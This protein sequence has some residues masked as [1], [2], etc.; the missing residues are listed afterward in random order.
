M[1]LAAEEIEVLR[2]CAVD[3]WDTPEMRAR[4]SKL[5]RR[6]NDAAIRVKLYKLGLTSIDDR[7]TF[8]GKLELW[9]AELSKAS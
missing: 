7:I 1:S 2:L 8:K 6:V 4:W 9:D 5:A 3:D